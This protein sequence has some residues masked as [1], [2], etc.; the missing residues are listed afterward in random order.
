MLKFNIAGRS[1]RKIQHDSIIV[2][3]GTGGRFEFE[4]GG[5]CNIWLPSEMHLKLKY[6]DIP[7]VQNVYFSCQ[8]V[9][10]AV[11]LSCSVQN[12]KIVWQPLNQLFTNEIS[13]DLSLRCV[14]NGYTLLQQSPGF[15]R[16][17]SIATTP[18]CSDS[19]GHNTHYLWPFKSEP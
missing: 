8:I 9:L 12:F 4:S 7:F 19:N 13:R 3:V 18:E 17:A 6:H 10:T 15:E 5:C 2:K 16:I 14:S 1:F 11:I